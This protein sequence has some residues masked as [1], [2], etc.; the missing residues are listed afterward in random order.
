L[1]RGAVCRQSASDATIH[2]SRLCFEPDQT[3]MENTPGPPFVGGLRPRASRRSCEI[4]KHFVNRAGT[5]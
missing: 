5:R 3:G 1:H 2:D 4:L